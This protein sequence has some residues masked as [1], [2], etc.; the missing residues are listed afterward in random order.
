[1]DRLRDRMHLGQVENLNLINRVDQFSPKLNNS[2]F[3]DHFT[4]SPWG[5]QFPMEGYDLLRV[6]ANSGMIKG[7]PGAYVGY[8]AAGDIVVGYNVID[9]GLLGIKNYMMRIVIASGVKDGG[10]ACVA[11]GKLDVSGGLPAVK[12][13]LGLYFMDGTTLANNIGAILRVNTFGDISVILQRQLPSKVSQ[14]DLGNIE[15]SYVGGRMSL[16]IQGTHIGVVSD[17][18]V[19]NTEARTYKYFIGLLNTTLYSGTG[20]MYNFEINIIPL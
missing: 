13:Y 16:T 19:G 3:K 1:M 2:I 14:Y 17:T 5:S 9:P 8:K 20:Y 6:S 11:F 7:L 12:G 15:F 10:R 4:Q 18:A